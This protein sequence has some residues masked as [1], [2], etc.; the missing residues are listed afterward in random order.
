MFCRPIVL[1]LLNC[2]TETVQVTEGRMRSA[3]RVLSIT[4]L[5]DGQ[6]ADWYYF[7]MAYTI[8]KT[9]QLN[10]LAAVM[11]RQGPLPSAEGFAVGHILP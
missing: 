7:W 11:H 5:G 8:V 10:Q 4:P 2:I 3:G 6:S 1:C 9:V